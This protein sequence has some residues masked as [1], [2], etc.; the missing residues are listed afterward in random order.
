MLIRAPRG[1]LRFDGQVAR[2]LH[3]RAKCQRVF[4]TDT[5]KG[6]KERDPARLNKALR[7]FR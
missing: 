2:V 4:V 6:Y 5:L 7:R 3:F 1:R